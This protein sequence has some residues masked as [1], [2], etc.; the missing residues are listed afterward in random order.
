MEAILK[1]TTKLKIAMVF[2]QVKMKKDLED[3]I[4]STTRK[5]HKCTNCSSK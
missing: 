1:Y 5:L 2:V 4:I 3:K